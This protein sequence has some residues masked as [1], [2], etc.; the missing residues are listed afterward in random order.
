MATSMLS[1]VVIKNNKDTLVHHYTTKN[2]NACFVF[3]DLALMILE[4]KWPDVLENQNKYLTYWSPIKPPTNLW[5][6]PFKHGSEVS[7]R[8]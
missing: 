5:F 1:N 2:N 3:Y 8:M 4:Q 6:R 7:I